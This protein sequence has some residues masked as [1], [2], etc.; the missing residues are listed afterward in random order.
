[1]T[2]ALLTP[3]DSSRSSAELCA[4][5]ECGGARRYGR[6][7]VMHLH[8]VRRT[9][10]PGPAESV[11]GTKGCQ[12]TGCPHAHRA[13]GYCVRHWRENR[14]PK[15]WCAARRCPHEVAEGIWCAEHGP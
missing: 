7:C 15:G 2:T 14:P 1:M 8:R 12:V 10:L 5:P 3:S 6:W 13:R 4:V 11:Y 9:G